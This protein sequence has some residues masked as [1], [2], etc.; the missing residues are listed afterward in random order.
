MF[1]YDFIFNLKEKKIG[2]I[3][4]FCSMNEQL[5]YK[6]CCNYHFYHIYRAVCG[7]RLCGGCPRICVE[8]GTIPAVRAALR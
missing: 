7:A 3:K 8:A 6:E 2:F 1:D 5:L 4:S